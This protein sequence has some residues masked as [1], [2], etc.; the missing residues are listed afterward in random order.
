MKPMKRREFLKTA[1]VAAIG[2][3]CIGSARRLH[4]EE[5]RK[6]TNR[7]QEF[8][9]GESA[10]TSGVYDVFHDKI[11]GEHHAQQHQV[12]VEAGTVFPRCRGCREWVK[13]RLAEQ[14]EYI[15]NDPHFEI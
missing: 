5:R 8:K 6:A 14:A 9:P 2:A 13:F 10:T 11:D 12:I 4:A 1:G 7:E 3:G 15:G